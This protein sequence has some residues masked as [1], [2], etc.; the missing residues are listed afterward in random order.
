MHSKTSM[1]LEPNPTDR[2]RRQETEPIRAGLAHRIATFVG[3]GVER[4]TSLPGLSFAKRKAPTPPTSYLYDPSISMIIRGK[5]RV[6]LGGNTYVYDESRFL[7]TAIKLPTV[8][9][10]LEASP[11]APYLSLLMRLDLQ[12]ARQMIADVDRHEANTPAAGTAMATG[13]ATLELF[14][15]IKRLVDLLDEPQDLLHLGALIQREII[16]R[17]LTSPAGARFRETVL[18]GTQ[19]QRTARAIAWLRENYTQPLRMEDL[20]K[21]AGMGVSTLHHHFR[22]MTAMSP[23]Q[24]QKHLRLHEAR[25]I[26]LGENVDAATVAVRVGYESAS[27]FNREYRRMFGASPIRDVAPLRMGRVKQD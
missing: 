12:A 10:V 18:L 4:A 13:P 2:R 6:Q 1:I 25:R 27:Q 19:S 16:Y 3:D 7:L 20:A 22:A 5:K 8:T 17:V 14:D 24:Y 9:E 21:L 15:A 26:L 23:L 11:E